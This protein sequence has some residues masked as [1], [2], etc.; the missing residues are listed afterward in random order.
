MQIALVR[1]FLLSVLCHLFSLGAVAFENAS[2][3]Q[4]D[5]S[6]YKV[7]LFLSKSCPCSDSHVNHL[8]NLSTKYRNVKFFGVIT[9]QFSPSSSTEI[10][11]YYSQ[12][13][14]RFPLIKDEQ[15]ILIKEYQ[16]LKTPHS[17]ILSKD[18]H[19][20]YTK[21]YEGGVTDSRD[22]SKATK[23]FLSENLAALTHGKPLKYTVGKSLGC[24]IRRI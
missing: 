14:F 2:V 4:R 9:D 19:G 15:Q 17:I 11:K 8:N 24:Y 7:L 21:V 23:E 16:A 10:Q 6:K 13:H 5:Q 22:F 20:S 12:Q 1:Y 18:G 3:F